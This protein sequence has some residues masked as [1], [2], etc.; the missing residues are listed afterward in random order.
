VNIAFRHVRQLEVN[1]VGDIIHINAT[2]G[3]IGCDQNIHAPTFE[4]AESAVTLAL[5]AIAVDRFSTEASFLKMQLNPVCAT[6]G[7]REHDGAFQARI[8]QNVSQNAALGTCFNVQNVL[9]NPLNWL[10]AFRHRNFGWLMEKLIRELADRAGH[11]G[12]KQN[13]LSLAFDRAED[14]PDWRQEAHV[15]HLI[16]FIERNHLNIVEAENAGF[17]VVHQA[18]RGRDEEI[19][20]ARHRLDLRAGPRAT[21][22]KGD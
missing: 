21:D 3:D 17:H 20:A 16:R 1:D 9:V 11:G 22:H 14:V 15:Q 13:R 8:A 19:Y 10:C 12:G 6:L 2:G 5:A 18:A 4:A 7:T